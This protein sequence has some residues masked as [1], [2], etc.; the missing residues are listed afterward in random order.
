MT[1]AGRCGAA[2]SLLLIPA[3]GQVPGPSVCAL[4]AG[5][6]GWHR[7]DDG[8]EWKLRETPAPEAQERLRRLIPH[9]EPRQAAELDRLLEADSVANEIVDLRSRTQRAE[10]LGAEAK[11]QLRVR[12]RQVNELCG[13]GRGAIVDVIAERDTHADRGW[14]DEHDREL[15]HHQLVD[16]AQDY[17]SRDVAG[18]AEQR[19]AYVK[20][21]SLLLAA[22][23]V[24]DHEFPPDRR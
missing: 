17:A 2:G 6:F 23:D 7:A 21:A 9:L 8:L 16:L 5:H 4:P 15:G 24:L 18:A 11:R 14:T 3:A 10:D 12:D 13:A 1:S 20:A 19:A 22:I